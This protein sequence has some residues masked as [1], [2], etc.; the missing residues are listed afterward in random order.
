[1]LCNPLVCALAENFLTLLL[2][3]KADE[4]PPNRRSTLTL[5]DKLN[6]EQAIV[7]SY[8]LNNDVGRANSM[9]AIQL[10][11]HIARKLQDQV[12]TWAKS[13]DGLVGA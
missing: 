12:Q 9:Q 4:G 13:E 7:R 11:R 1:M 5:V 3:W 8:R 6:L 10:A 2:L